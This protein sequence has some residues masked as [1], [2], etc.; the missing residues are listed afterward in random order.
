MKNK[1]LT[2]NQLRRLPD[3]LNLLKNLAGEGVK[4][5]SCQT[6]AD[7]LNLNQEQ[8]R[9]DIALI[10]TIDGIP[11]RGRDINLLIKDIETILGYDDTHNAI[12]VG[13][14]NLGSALL[15]FNGFE[16]Y[17]L[18]IVAAFDGNSNVIGK[19]MNNI[20]VYSITKIE[21]I[22]PNVKARI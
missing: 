4:Y 8:V 15:N 3:Y 14:G 21:D 22:L 10:S 13:V 7:C 16:Q 19:R 12:L 5:I 17:G 2:R 11:N 1:T 18:K 6:I 20:P 9:K